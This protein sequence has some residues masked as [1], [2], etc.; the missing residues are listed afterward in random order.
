MDVFSGVDDNVMQYYPDVFEPPGSFRAA[1][2]SV[3]N[4]EPLESQSESHFLVAYSLSDPDQF[5]NE[6]IPVPAT[7]QVDPP[8]STETSHY[9]NTEQSSEICISSIC[10]QQRNRLIKRVHELSVENQNLLMNNTETRK[11]L[12]ENELQLGLAQDSN[13]RLQVNF[14]SEIMT[15]RNTNWMLETEVNTL[16]S[17]NRACKEMM[18]AMNSELVGI[19]EKINK[20][21]ELNFI[22]DRDQN[23]SSFSQD[24]I[25]H[26]NNFAVSPN[27]CT[28]ANCAI[29]QMKSKL[30]N[31]IQQKQ[32]ISRCCVDEQFAQESQRAEKSFMDQD[33]EIESTEELHRQINY[34]LM[35]EVGLSVLNKRIL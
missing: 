6:I 29:K 21:C 16:K 31:A 28:E 30:D 25:N 23:A 34:K 35:D 33:H 18:T 2:A 4:H 11:R 12:V 5:T 8:V 22:G 26:N 7:V 17:E 15:L 24:N 3:D 13:S 10:L 19:H 32:S 1:S 27:P 20:L 9:V 14:N